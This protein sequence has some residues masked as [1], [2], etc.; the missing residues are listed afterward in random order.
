MFHSEF[1]RQVD[2]LIHKGYPN[3]AGLSEAAFKKTTGAPP[4]YN[5]DE[6][7]GEV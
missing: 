5:R 6:R 7:E 2:N 1:K 4:R 3:L